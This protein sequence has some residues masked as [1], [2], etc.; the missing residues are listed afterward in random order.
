MPVWVQWLIVFAIFGFL[1]FSEYLR[2]RRRYLD[3]NREWKQVK[4]H[5]R[6]ENDSDFTK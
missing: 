5:L 3:L 4:R 6:G 2:R 1:L